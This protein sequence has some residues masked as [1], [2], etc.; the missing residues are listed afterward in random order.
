MDI[1]QLDIKAKEKEVVK[2][3]LPSYQM[4]YY[5]ERLKN[6]KRKKQK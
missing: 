4:A 6:V 5:Q 2:Y 1:K 3:A